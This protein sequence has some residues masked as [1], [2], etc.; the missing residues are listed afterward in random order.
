MKY[1][2]YSCDIDTN[3]DRVIEYYFKNKNKSIYRVFEIEL[4]DLKFWGCK[5]DI[6]NYYLS[7]FRDFM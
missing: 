3:F 2:E 6:Q 4:D 5:N 7:V 1:S